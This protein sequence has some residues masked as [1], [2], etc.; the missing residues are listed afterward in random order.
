MKRCTNVS[1]SLIAMNPSNTVQKQKTAATKTTTTIMFNNQM[2]QGQQADKM[3]SISRRCGI[4]VTT[5]VLLCFLFVAFLVKTCD[6]IPSFIIN[7]DVRPRCISVE[8]PIDTLIRVH[9]EAP[10]TCCT[11]HIGTCTSVCLL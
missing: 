2:M 3:T 10:G 8:E 6:A 9:Y 11:L 5:P 1:F 7:E 4:T